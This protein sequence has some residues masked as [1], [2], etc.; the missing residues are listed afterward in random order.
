M[1]KQ[2]KIFVAPFFLLIIFSC[3]NNKARD[4]VR[5]TTITEEVAYNNLF[6]DSLQLLHFINDHPEFNQF[7]QQFFDFYKRRNYEYA[8]FDSSGLQEQAKNFMNLLNVT[9]QQM[10][11]SSLYNKKLNELY[12]QFDSGLVNPNPKISPLQTELYLTGQFFVYAS[13]VYKGKDVDATELG[14]YI[15]RRKYNLT[16]LLD[17]AI[18]SR[19]EKQKM[20][21]PL[22]RQFN[23]MQDAIAK[24]NHIKKTY[25]WDSIPLPGK[26]YKI[27]D[28]AHAISL[29]KQRLYI[30]G[31]YQAEDTSSVYDTAFITAVKAF[32]QRMGLTADGELGRNTITELN[33]PVTQRIKT[34]LINLE[35]IRWMPAEGDSTF[36]LVNIP[37]FRLHV[38]DTG[39]QLF[40]MK[41]IVGK[42]GTNTVIFTGYLKYIVFSPYWNVPQ[43]IVRKE[44]LPAINRNPAYISSH[45]MEITG[46]SNGLPVVRQKPGPDNALGHV[47]FLFPNEY[48]I[49]LHDTPNRELFSQ[50]NRMF[51]HGCIRIE[52]PKKLAEFLLRSKPEYTSSV[53]DSLMHLNH[54]NW[55]TLPNPVRVFI[56]YFTAWTDANGKIN[57]RK[58]IYGHDKKL[59]SRLF[60][61]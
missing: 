28:T 26:V 15:P 45:N 16:D 39:K 38:F 30:L 44:I 24:Y 50:T 8:W 33:T 60:E 12:I 52:E 19:G 47:K 31:D 51:S 36:I 17:S 4:V 5:D 42:A 58:D 32:Q 2:W 40:Q 43:S 55:I 37:E 6:M 18:L 29:I 49:Y 46:Y 3:E 57:F 54:D 35:R 20:Y 48:N 53:I 23:R 21:L 56:G 11:D 34:L 25:K 59:A 9:S 1:I 14:W 10:D 41:I 27:G 61:P 22:S 7:Q 13:K